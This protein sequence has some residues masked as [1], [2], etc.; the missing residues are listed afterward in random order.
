[1]F[2]KIIK[3]TFYN[4]FS[5]VCGYIN[6]IVIEADFLLFAPNSLKSFHMVFRSSFPSSIFV[7]YTDRLASCIIDDTSFLAI[8]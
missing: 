5:K 8:L 4:W 3:I 7:L 1:M 2:L 6:K